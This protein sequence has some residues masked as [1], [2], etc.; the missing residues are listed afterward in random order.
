[1]KG[2]QGSPRED[3]LNEIISVKKT[4]CWTCFNLFVLDKQIVQYDKSFCSDKCVSYFE[5]ENQVL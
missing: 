2:V 3:D 1:M 5:K 4:S